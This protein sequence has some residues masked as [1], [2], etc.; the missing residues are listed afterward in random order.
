MTRVFNF[1][2]RHRF[3]TAAAVL[4]VL[5]LGGW[6]AFALRKEGFP[7][8]STN[9]IRVLIPCSC[10]AEARS[11][12]R[13]VT[14][15]LELRLRG[16]PGVGEVR[17]LSCPGA[18]HLE[19]LVDENAGE[20]DFGRVDAAV[21][22]AAACF[23]EEFGEE[24]SVRRLTSSDLPVLELG[25]AGP[26][27]EVR[28]VAGR[29]CPL[30][31]R[32][33]GVRD[34][35]V[36]GLSNG[37]AGLTAIPL[38]GCRGP[39]VRNNGRRGASMFVTK[40]P[41][42]DILETVDLLRG[43]VERCQ[44]PDEVELAV[45]SDA[46]RLTRERLRLVGQNALVGFLLVLVL[47]FLVHDRRTAFWTAMGIPF[48]LLGVLALLHAGGESLNALTLAG[49]I[50][51]LGMLVD[52][53]IVV[54]DAVSRA[55]RDGLSPARAAAAGIGAVWRPVTAATATTVIAFL[56]L[57][58]MR[59]LPGKFI[60]IVPLVAVLALILSLAECFLLLPVHICRG[61]TARAPGQRLMAGLEAGYRR[62]L[63]VALRTRYLLIVGFVASLVLVGF[64]AARRLKFDPF[65]QDAAESFTVRLEMPPGTPA[66]RTEQV[67]RRVEALLM[68]LPPSELAGLSTRVGTEDT[69]AAAPR[70]GMEDRAIAFAHLNPLAARERTAAQVIEAV[71]PSLERIARAEGAAV[72]IALV[73][74]GPPLGR[75]F[76][77]RVSGADDPLR[78]NTADRV[79]EFLSGLEGVRD[80][81]LCRATSKFVIRRA[82]FARTTRISGN[83]NKKLL[84]PEEL[85]ARVRGKFDCEGPAP[86]SFAGQPVENTRVFGRLHLAAALALVGIYLVMAL[87]F[88]SPAKPLI[89]M[90]AVPF[91]AGGIAICLLVHGQPFSAFAGTALIGLFGVV[92]N[93]SIVMVHRI[94]SAVRDGARAP[95]ALAAA[96]ASRL[97][98]VL[99]TTATTVLGVLP[100][101]YALGGYDPFVSPMCLSLAWGLAFGTL[102]TLLLVPALYAVGLDL[103]RLTR[104]S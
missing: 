4:T 11:V 68:A 94:R 90:A 45:L 14:A 60:W 5:G 99:L 42:A 9:R 55:R 22:A 92:V 61:G 103:R 26:A 73:R 33:P 102:V 27:D 40:R 82:G 66:R 74:Y 10:L 31:E 51:V 52:D 88:A 93:D 21:R 80:L 53:A 35:T 39:T 37:S 83:L 78:E 46:S 79:R 97:R 56:P 25:L 6:S 19:V 77:V 48:S 47:L 13:H 81:E 70:G 71:R 8:V 41:E 96:A 100:A 84:S 57:L 1:L 38:P 64:L 15:P 63:E 43:E 62:L 28:R 44:L 59:G 50:I 91:G 89:V 101:A 65:P 36:L 17:S 69:W 34:V 18:A 12:E 54:S 2:L 3:L 16:V 87:A 23:R 67:L 76:E 98:P 30:L 95:A 49:C 85:M 20:R 29:L 24:P 32:T 58:G 75:P 7:N 86:I 72:R 104:P